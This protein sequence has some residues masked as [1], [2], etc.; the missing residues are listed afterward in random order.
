MTELQLRK[1][2]VQTFEEW[3][4]YSKANG[5]HKIII[6]LYNTQ[7]PLPVGYKMT[8]SDAWCAATVTAVGVKLGITEYILPECSCS[9]MIELYKKAGLWV[10]NDSYVPKIGDLIMYDW[11]DD[12]NFAVTDNKGAPEH[13]G[14][15]TKVTYGNMTIIEG[16]KHNK[17]AYRTIKINGRYIRGFCTPDY[18]TA[19]KKYG[20]VTVKKP[21]YVTVKA[22]KLQKGDTGRAVK[23]LQGALNAIGFDCG[24][25]DGSFGP[26][27]ES[28][29]KKLQKAG[30]IT[31]DGIVNQKTWG[32][33]L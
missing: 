26:T 24:E 27:T 25:V 22:Q 23:V 31:V 6:D 10:E 29:V 8:Y 14:M 7:N 17:V 20:K 30:A 19:A 13:V 28:A 9:R 5:K 16:N 32:L 3:L 4:G 15:V 12:K 11:D 18:K 2:A 1:L 33:I 21:V